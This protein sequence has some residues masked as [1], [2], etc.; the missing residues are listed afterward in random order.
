MVIKQAEACPEVC[1]CVCVCVY[2]CVLLYG[3]LH[4]HLPPP[5]IH[6][7]TP[8]LKLQQ[9]YGKYCWPIKLH[10]PSSIYHLL[11]PDMAYQCVT[12]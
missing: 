6:M 3:L 12:I 9:I 5:Q 4:P 1:V 8:F 11:F 2:V 10:T 7:H